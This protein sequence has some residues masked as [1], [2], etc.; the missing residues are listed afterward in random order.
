MKQ[1]FVQ[2][3]C[4]WLLLPLLSFASGNNVLHLEQAHINL[5]DQASLQRGARLFV[6]YCMGCHSLQYMRYNRM[7]KDIGIVDGEG[8]VAENVLKDNLIFTGDTIFDTM[9]NAMSKADAKE[10]FGV[11]PPDLTLVARVRGADWL[12]TYLLGFYRD[13]KRPFG[14]N[15]FI[16]R[17]V[18]MP[19][20]LLPLQGE[21]LPHYGVDSNGHLYVDRVD[22]KSIGSMSSIQ[23][24]AAI[25]DLVN[26]LVYV[27]EPAQLKRE[28]LGIWV[29]M[30]L[31]VFIVLTY[32]LKREYWKDV[33]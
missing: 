20:V 28:S 31:A 26:F 21:Q 13:D 23:F 14:S 33:E 8:K 32:L 15:N 25:N 22:L 10:W 27:G 7:A 16:F 6:N 19:N 11:V 24:R 9:R 12:L 18:A 1:R 5:H 4:I 2:F 30:F 17:D 29:L 3:V